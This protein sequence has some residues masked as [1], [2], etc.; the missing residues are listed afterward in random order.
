MLMFVASVTIPACANQ[1]GVHR[2]RI[3]LIG[4]LFIQSQLHLQ[5]SHL[6]K[7]YQKLSM[8]I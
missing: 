2:K 6:C 3:D 7:K 4:H 1:V 5:L 8:K